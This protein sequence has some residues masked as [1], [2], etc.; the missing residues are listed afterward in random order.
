MRAFRRACSAAGEGF[1]GAGRV[2][3]IWGRRGR[4]PVGWGGEGVLR[5]RR[6]GG[7][8]V[9]WS[10]LT[11]GIEVAKG[12]GWGGEWQSGD[13]ALEGPQLAK[14]KDIVKS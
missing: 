1:V 6:G 9:G 12:N 2:E 7:R 10:I 3:R 13:R 14:E 4:R 8:K 11:G 5:G